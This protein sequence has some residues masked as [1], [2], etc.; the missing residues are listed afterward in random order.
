M[1]IILSIK[2]KNILNL[3]Y[4]EKNYLRYQDIAK[5]LGVSSKTISRELTKMETAL[6]SFGI[7]IKRK[8][9]VGV[10]LNLT[11]DGIEF[12]NTL[13]LEDKIEDEKIER[14]QQI[15]IALIRE[16]DILKQFYFSSI[17]NVTDTTIRTDLHKVEK[18]LEKYNIKLI[19][20]SGLGIYIEGKEE[21]KRRVLSDYIHQKLGTDLTID[22]LKSM[23]SL[24]TKA[25]DFLSTLVDEETITNVENIT[26]MVLKKYNYNLVEKSYTGLII[27][28]TLSIKR[29]QNGDSI[30]DTNSVMPI[31]E[32]ST[33][34]KIAKNINENLGILFNITIPQTETGYI[35]LH[36]LG[37]RSNID[38]SSGFDNLKLTIIA[39][40]IINI[41]KEDLYFSTEN[42]KSLVLDLVKHLNPA[43]FRLNKGLSIHNPLLDSLYK[44]YPRFMEIAKKASTPLLKYLNIKEIPEGEI[45]F[46]AMHLGAKVDEKTNIPNLKI[47]V[48]CPMGIGTSRFLAKQ[49][50]DEFPNINIISTL[51]IDKAKNIINADAIISTVEIENAKVPCLKLDYLL[52]E[53]NLN[54]LKYFF[55]TIK[56]KDYIVEDTID[57]KV[58]LEEVQNKIK[59]I[60]K[61]YNKLEIFKTNFTNKANIIDYILDELNIEN[62]ALVKKAIDRREEIGS[63]IYNE[64]LVLHAK[65]EYVDD[66]VFA[67]IKC[68]KEFFIEKQKVSSIIFIL[69]PMDANENIIDILGYLPSKIVEDENLVN[70]LKTGTKVAIKQKIALLYKSYLKKELNFNGGI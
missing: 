5:K 18:H 56:P 43:I 31:N 38:E 62:K 46:I 61:I 1:I 53:S 21:D 60:L 15:L 2:Q 67:I 12:L 40:E 17:F 9:G 27:H 55:L 11:S 47:I 24:D 8:S 33:E 59:A 10:K 69:M 37:A 64:I 19:R 23:N 54:K 29:I 42:K 26:N 39:R 44:N 51:N 25:H 14:W 45:G 4:I 52:D 68:E 32:N 70:T 3:L 30:K 20:R 7:S 22:A 65:T 41:A 58:E 35:V 49:I 34:Y 63:S 57:F 28:L 66:I 6:N 36:L 16:K 13:F 50:K 48:S